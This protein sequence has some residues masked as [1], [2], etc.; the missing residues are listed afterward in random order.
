MSSTFSSLSRGAERSP[1][2]ILEKL[3]DPRIVEALVSLLDKSDKLALFAQTLEDF[4]GRSEVLLNSMSKSVG[5][6]GRVGVTALGKTFENIDL[7]DLKSASGQLQGMLPVWRDFVGEFNTLKEAGVFDAE[8][9]KIIGRTGRA[10]ASTVRDPTAHSSETR[11]VFNLLSL[12]KDRDIARSL[13]F[14]ISFARHFGGDLNKGE[15]GSAASTLPAAA[16]T[17][18]SVH[19]KVS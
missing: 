16:A 6:L 7:D 13:N 5:Q 18:A 4:L 11:G 15:P 9:V 19:R 1:D 14:L 10:M 3:E 12:L 17:Q 8:V 2:M